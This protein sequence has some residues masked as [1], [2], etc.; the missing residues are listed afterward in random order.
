[1]QAKNKKITRVAKFLAVI[2]KLW[3]V[4]VSITV[5]FSGLG[6]AFG[7]YKNKNKVQTVKD[8]TYIETKVEVSISDGEYMSFSD[9]FNNSCIFIMESQELKKEVL[10]SID[11]DE[12][13]GEIIITKLSNITN[14]V[15]VTVSSSSKEDG[16]R[17]LNM[18]I[19]KAQRVLNQDFRNNLNVDGSFREGTEESSKII[20]RQIGNV[21][22]DQVVV[23]KEIKTIVS[24][25]VFVLIGA[26]LG[27]V[28]A[29]IVVY[30]FGFYFVVHSPNEVIK[31]FNINYL[32]RFDNKKDLQKFGEKEGFVYCISNKKSVLCEF[33]YVVDDI[34]S[35]NELMNKEIVLVIEEDKDTLFFVEKTQKLLQNKIRGFVIYK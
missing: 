35:S 3:Y 4:I 22:Q 32:S 33:S 5:C 31:N 30:L 14:M 17:I 11:L 29:I 19:E 34:L 13:G 20:L 8:Y 12:G 2:K 10:K 23:K 27:F 26:F 6:L 16:L 15:R 1:M 21:E 7:I 9:S 28:I 25:S 24:V 18:Y